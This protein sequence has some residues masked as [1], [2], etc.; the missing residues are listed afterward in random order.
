MIFFTYNLLD[1]VNASVVQIEASGASSPVVKGHTNA[2]S[3]AQ[4][5]SS[6]SSSASTAKRK[7]KRRK[8][9]ASPMPVPGASPSLPLRDNVKIPSTMAAR[10]PN[11]SSSTTAASRDAASLFEWHWHGR[12]AVVRV[13]CSEGTCAYG[14]READALMLQQWLALVYGAMLPGSG[15]PAAGVVGLGLGSLDE[16]EEEDIL[17][18]LCREDQGKQLKLGSTLWKELPDLSRAA[19][20]RAAMLHRL[21]HMTVEALLHALSKH[22][23]GPLRSAADASVP[24]GPAPSSVV[25]RKLLDRVL[26]GFGSIGC[27]WPASIGNSKGSGRRKDRD[28]V[29]ASRSISSSSLISVVT[30]MIQVSPIA[31]AP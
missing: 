14:L 11:S 20:S 15:V 2:S 18:A 17:D 31:S 19:L 23:L 8:S 9:K 22:C 4:P 10:T 13:E 3:N 27:E 16:E 26:A 1:F 24:L 6:S 30:H 29:E 25:L 5:S 28:K 12:S 7:R 21:G